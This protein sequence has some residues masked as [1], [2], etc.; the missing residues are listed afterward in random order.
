M[1]VR[2]TRW[3]DLAEK[4]S[5]KRAIYVASAALAA[6]TAAAYWLVL[7]NGF[8]FDDVPYLVENPSVRHGLSPAGIVWAFTAFYCANWHP[9]TWLSTMLDVSLFGMNAAG[10]H[11]VSLL[12]HLANTVLLMLL[13]R[14]MTGSLWKSA[15]VAGLFALHPL[16][17]ESVAWI[18]ERK[19]VLSTL[20]MLL[21]VWAY[22][23]YAESPSVRKYIVVAVLFA[24][25]LMAKPMLVTLPIVLLMLDYWP[26]RR[27][28]FEHRKG[29]ATLAQLAM[30]KAPLLGLS[31][32]SSVITFFAQ[33]SIGAVVQLVKFPLELRIENAVVSYGAYLWKMVWPSGLAAYYPYPAKGIPAVLVFASAA[34]LI[35]ISLAVWRNAKPR[36]YLA[37]GWLWYLITLIPV[38]GIVQVGEQ[39]MADRYTYIPLMGISVAVTWLVVE[40]VRRPFLLSPILGVAVLAVLGVCTWKQVQYWKSDYVL[41]E[42]AAVATRDNKLAEN[43]FGVQLEAQ[44]K[45]D[46][47]ILHY[48]KAL[49][50]DPRY[51]DA[52]LDLGNA[53]LSQGK[54]REAVREYSRV[55]KDE[56]GNQKASIGLAAALAKQGRGDVAASGFSKVLETDP[57][58]ADAHYNLGLML[59]REGKLDEAIQHFTKAVEINPNYAKAHN[60][61]GAALGQQ[62]RFD[63]AIPHYM[64]ALKI[65]PRSPEA[66]CNL[67]VA[68][69]NKGQMDE[70]Q[71][72]LVEAVALKPNYAEAHNVLGAVLAS[73]GN[74][75][76]AMQHF[77]MAVKLNP[78]IAEAHYNLGF[79]LAGQSKSEEAMKEYR[80]AIRLKP[81]YGVAHTNLAVELF[82]NGRYAEAW[83][84]VHLGARYGSPPNPQFVQALTAKMPEPR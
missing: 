8:V 73:K 74:V 79:G 12:F 29:G 58:N 44:G 17:V 26:L 20:L 45:L 11:A 56:P 65:D 61:L 5:D 28:S 66:H 50:I 55:L 39:S 38:I 63:E 31:A 15:F 52:R 54:T 69:A 47:A 1:P 4:R 23:S 18:A 35:L 27:L 25:G 6:A 51:S 72:H 37:V 10:H 30:E 80:E 57:N 22:V 7:K 75:S 71:Q 34:V 21:T 40:K 70:A 81:D 67:G 36:P 78:A 68:L 48:R 16:H 32:A 9:L 43:N 19:D 2:L 60:N 62:G 49:R 82:I 41:F 53:L 42:R 76:E 3:S 84:E 83:D 59:A 33:R 46:E 64:D 77:A 24:L 13:L 14:R